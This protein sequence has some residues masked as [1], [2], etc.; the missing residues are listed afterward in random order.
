MKKHCITEEKVNVLI[1][2]IIIALFNF[3]FLGAEYLFDDMM[4]YTADSEGVVIAQ[5]YILGASVIGF[6]LFPLANRLV[7]E[8]AKYLLVLVCSVAGVA[9]IFLI[10]QH[11]SYEIILISGLFLF[12]LLGVAGSGVHYLVLR[13]VGGSRH[14]A[15]MM[16]TAYAM[17]ILFQFIN[18][19]CVKNDMV[20]SI[21]LSAF[22]MIFLVFAMRLGNTVALKKKEGI[23]VPEKKYVLKNPVVAGGALIVCVV[24][25]TCVFSTLDNVVTLVHATGS[26]DIGEWP[27]LLL[28]LSGLAAG[29]LY[30]IKERHYMSVIMYC[31]TLLSTIC[32]VV[33]EMG[34]TFLTG[35]IVFYLSA[36]F[37]VVFFTVG[38]MDLARHMHIPEF[39]AGFG[40]ATNNMC[41]VITATV[42]LSLLS[43][44]NGMEIMIVTLI[45]FVL[46]SIAVYIYQNQF[47]DGKVNKEL[48]ED[49]AEKFLAFS[50][51]FSLTDREQDVLKVLLSSDENVQEIAEQLLMSRAALYRHIASLNEKTETKSRIGLLQFYYTW[52]KQNDTF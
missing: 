48:S 16:G 40:R 32:V 19:N 5:S 42:S 39:W 21:V 34:G 4:A 41:A 26:V 8:G 20:Q 38:F 51:S 35:L 36:G 23:E 1:S 31:V 44:G 2:I 3:I 17:G 13:T 47:R 29:F 24:L 46:I 28:A 22:V 11:A 45:L 27:R 50:E 12:V 49:A 6:L 9:C 14:L 43:L 10:Q 15:K 18:N 33:I 30:D 7:K 37:F 25:M 52:K